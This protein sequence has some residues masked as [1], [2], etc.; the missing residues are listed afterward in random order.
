MRNCMC[1]VKREGEREWGK[2]K[3]IFVFLKI[4]G[5]LFPAW[6]DVFDGT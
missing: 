4:S 1:E 3:N 6:I 5:T 2:K